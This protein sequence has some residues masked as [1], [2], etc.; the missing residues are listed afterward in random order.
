MVNDNHEL[1]PAAPSFK[2]QQI[3]P[4]IWTMITEIAP[5]AHKSRLFGVTSAEAAAA[6]MLKGYELGL[7]ITTAFEYISIIQGRTSLKPIGA[8]ALVQ[9]S[10]ELAASRIVDE[11][12][13]QGNPFACTVYLK[14]TNGAEY[15]SRVT[16]EDARRSGVVKP[17][18]GWETYPANML[19]WRA[20]GF[21]IDVVFPDVQGGMKRADEFGA[22]V[23]ADGNIVEVQWADVSAKPVA[24]LPDT[25]EVPEVVVSGARTIEP[26]H[27][28]IQDLIDEHGAEA[29]LK[30][31]QKVTAGKM[32]EDQDQ[33]NKIA[34]ELQL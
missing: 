13:T 20:L 34:E 6:I 2:K 15:T 11:N 30:A 22:T 21:A 8:W 31:M 3:T 9:A 10:G 14:R 1:V 12:D 19:R 16:M 28:S 7:G 18:S 5:V 26:K 23:D 27:T 24:K 32:P 25:Q 17:G 33:V 29:V 4:N